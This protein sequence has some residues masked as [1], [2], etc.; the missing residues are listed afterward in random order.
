[1]PNY[2]PLG[3]LLKE[4]QVAEATDYFVELVEQNDFNYAA[5]A[6]QLEVSI[7]TLHG[8][9]KNHPQLRTA[10]NERKLKQARKKL[11][12]LKTGE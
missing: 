10:V 9:L 5:T 2:S 3:M 6:R 7:A 1:M 12:T 11:D 4:G 8:W